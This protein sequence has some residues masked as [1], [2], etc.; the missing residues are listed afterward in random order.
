MPNLT[1]L[2]STTEFVLSTDYSNY[3]P[4]LEM[5]DSWE[6]GSSFDVSGN[7]CLV[8]ELNE[9]F[10]KLTVQI[11]P[12][13]GFPDHFH[14][15]HER[16]E[17]LSGVLTDPNFPGQSWT[18][19][20]EII[21]APFDLHAPTNGGT[22][23]VFLTVDFFLKPPFKFSKVSQ[24]NKNLSNFFGQMMNSTNGTMN[25]AMFFLFGAG[26]VFGIEESVILAPVPL[27]G[28]IREIWKGNRKARWSGN[29]ITYISSFFAASLPWFGGMW[30]TLHPMIS[31]ALEGN[32]TLVAAV[33][34]P[35]LNE[36]VLLIKN[37]PWQ[38]SNV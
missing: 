8:T 31:A 22:K 11:L 16:I 18:S 34:A 12:G 36:L 27:W 9:D 32:W 4:V 30:E 28:A 3:Q 23:T 25:L 38:S 7:Q 19:G 15:V 2:I 5:V 29:I 37:K 24:T 13:K 33:A 1:K 10:V 6:V 26:L 35:F 20:Q 21:F 14:E 17:V